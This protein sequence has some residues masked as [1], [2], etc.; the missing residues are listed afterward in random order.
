MSSACRARTRGGSVGLLLGLVAAMA[1]ES[2]VGD[3]SWQAVPA[4]EAQGWLVSTTASPD[5]STW[6]ALGGA[7]EAGKIVRSADTRSWTPEPI[8]QVP[9][10][11]W[12]QVF[13]DGSSVVVGNGGTVLRY[14]AGAWTLQEVPTRE[15]LWGV[16]GA[17]PDDV[18]AVGGAGQRQGQATLLHYDGSVWRAVQLPPLERP[19]VWAL[20]KV[21][22]SAADDVYAVGQRGA[23]LHYDGRSWSEL[24][25]GTG[26]DLIAVYGVARD[27][28]AIV[29]GRSSGFVATFDG[30]RWSSRSL[31]PLPG[32]N[33]V[34]M[35]DRDTIHVAGIEGT[36][37]E[38][39][40]ATLAARPAYQETGLTFHALHGAG[41]RLLA[42]GGNL[43]ATAPPW[44]GLA[45]AQTTETP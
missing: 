13:A 9:L 35:G 23:V 15:D 18:W 12:G 44:L 26:D 38:V 28:V 19:N 8:P 10:L 43:D 25:L 21:W 24:G 34:W 32:L 3:A 2:E 42:V 4:L 27:R 40:F 11:N 31:A 41:A 17:R 37:A 14:A 1:C 30:A 7:P 36:L 45:R 16:W 22:G 5:G 20:F 6:L 33:G 29:G 39:D